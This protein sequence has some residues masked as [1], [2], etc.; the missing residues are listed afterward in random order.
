MD[1]NGVFRK[2]KIYFSQVSNVALRDNNLSL[3]AKGLYALIQSYITIEDYSL[4]KT[5]LQKVC[6][7]GRDAF[8]GAW[9]ELK[10]NGYLVQYKLK[11][12]GGTFY[13]EYDLLDTPE[14]IEKPQTENPHVETTNGKSTCGKTTHGKPGMYNNTDTNNTDINN[15]N[16]SSSSRNQ[17][18][19]KIFKENICELKKTTKPKFLNFC[20]KYDYE[21]INSILEYCA[22]INIKSYKGFETIISS[23]IEKDLF[24]AAAFINSIEMYRKKKK[25]GHNNKS[26]NTNTVTKSKKLKFDNFEARE[27][28]Y[29]SLEQKLLGWK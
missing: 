16:T 17:D 27:Y 6:K 5:T 8:N 4:Y 9:K 24:T 10:D 12:N 7:E 25:E 23:A 21:F 20:N 13:Y 2:K 11:N 19:E 22:E 18:L 14:K 3:K 26:K 1:N 28:D 15:T 29:N